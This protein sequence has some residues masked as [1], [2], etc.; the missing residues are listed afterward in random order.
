MSSRAAPSEQLTAMIAPI[1]TG[2]GYDLEN[3][4][5]T[6]AG[7]RSLVRVVVDGDDGITLDGVAELSRALS[8]ALDDEESAAMGS[9]PYVL[10][11]TSPGV[12]RPLTQPRHWRRATGRLVRVTGP[13]G[14]PVRGRVLRSAEEGVVIDVA[15][16]ERELAYRDIG[17][18]RVEVEFSRPK[19]SR[20]RDRS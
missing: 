13:D 2:A 1:V 15:G 16:A 19:D 12:D 4:V 5:V 14:A 17:S 10:E 20:A 7:R 6:P 9:S 11:V 18:A 8:A 3:I